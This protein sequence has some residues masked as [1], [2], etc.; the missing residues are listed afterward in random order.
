MSVIRS[1]GRY[2]KLKNAVSATFTTCCLLMVSSIESS[3]ISAYSMYLGAMVMLFV[4]YII[5]SSDNILKY[6]DDYLSKRQGLIPIATKQIIQ[7][8]KNADKVGDTTI[9]YNKQG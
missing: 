5:L 6:I 3:A 2:L 8:L 4:M 1:V 7:P 9:V